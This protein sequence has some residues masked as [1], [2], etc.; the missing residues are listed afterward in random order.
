MPLFGFCN[1]STE[2]AADELKMCSLYCYIRSE[3]V[4]SFRNRSIIL[5]HADEVRGTIGFARELRG[6]T[7][8]LPS[9]LQYCEVFSLSACSP[10][11]RYYLRIEMLPIGTIRIN[12]PLC[13]QCQF[14]RW[15]AEPIKPS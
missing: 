1:Q 8:V 11:L 10:L 4:E 2:T 12:C 9:R 3:S 14:N 13:N 7:F 15:P 5:E 6:H